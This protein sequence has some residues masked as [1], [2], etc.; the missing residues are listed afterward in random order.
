MAIT[1]NES[2]LPAAC[3]SQTDTGKRS[4]LRQ[5]PDNG[6]AK[7]DSKPVADGKATATATAGTA[8]AT[9]AAP[10]SGYQLGVTHLDA[11]FSDDTVKDKLLQIT[12]DV[13]GT[14]AVIWEGYANGNKGREVNFDPPLPVTAA[15]SIS[16][17][18]ASGG[19]AV[20]GK[21]NIVTVTQ[22]VGV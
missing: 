6:R 20:V 11:S 4:K 22:K 9:V 19:G 5:R 17:V 1:T 16:G 7:V 8:T 12:E 15:K 21:V 13:G 18:L 14:P 10:A 3:V 2:S